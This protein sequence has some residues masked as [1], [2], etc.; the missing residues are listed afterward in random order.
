M[1]DTNLVGTGGPA[2]ADVYKHG[3]ML[4][5]KLLDVLAE[6]VD[7]TVLCAVNKVHRPEVT[8]APALGHD[9]L[10]NGDHRSEPHSAGN[11][12]D[13]T[14]TGLVQDELATRRQ[15]FEA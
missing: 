6:S 15:R 10:R 5:G 11:E 1:S 3:R 8:G 2:V 4:S 7:E 9:V 14:G 12:Y 13:R